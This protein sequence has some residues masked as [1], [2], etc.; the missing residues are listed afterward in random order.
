MSSFSNGDRTA[1]FPKTSSLESQLAWLCVRNRR[2][3]G[4]T[5]SMACVRFVLGDVLT[6]QWA[7][8]PRMSLPCY[9]HQVSQ[10]VTT[11][12]HRRGIE[13]CIGLHNGQYLVSLAT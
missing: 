11:Q 4:H 7:G 12:A 5:T 2:E 10:C 9:C 6:L 13:S 1:Y 8:L 3:I